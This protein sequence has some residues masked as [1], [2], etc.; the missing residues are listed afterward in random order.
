M[1]IKGVFFTDSQIWFQMFMLLFC[2]CNTNKGFLKNL[3]PA[4][5]SMHI[6]DIVQNCS[7]T[8][9]M[10]IFCSFLELADVVIMNCQLCGDV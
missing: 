10:S 8:T 1:F 3:Q 4:R 9:F 5:M 7:P 2:L 6:F